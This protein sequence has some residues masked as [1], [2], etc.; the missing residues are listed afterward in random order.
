VPAGPI[1]T[2]ED[3]F[4]DPQIVARRMRI[5]REDEE[6]VSI[7]G[8]RLPILFD[9]RPAIADKPAPRLAPSRDIDRGG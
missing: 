8:L 5:D 2:V 3:V 4:A 9:D 1:N 7:P 6:G